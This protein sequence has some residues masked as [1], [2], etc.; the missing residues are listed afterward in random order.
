MTERM[1]DLGGYRLSVRTTGT[2][3]PAV[4][5]LASLGGGNDEWSAVA[6]LLSDTTHVVTYARA[7]IEDSNPLPADHAEQLRTAAWFATQLRTLLQ[8]LEIGPPYIFATGSIG[9]FIADRYAETWPEEVAG[10][11]LT[12]PTNPSPFRAAPWGERVLE[13]GD[14][15][16]RLR[17]SDLHAELKQPRNGHPVRAVVV[18]SAVGRWLRGRADEWAP[19]TL[20]EVDQRWQ[21][22][23]R[24]WVQRWSAQQVVADTAGHHVCREEPR[25]VATVVS[26]MVAAAREARDVHLD[27]GL[28]ATVGGALH[29]P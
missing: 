21:A 19:M 29:M 28:L 4:V 27:P 12:D 2:F 18:S 9:A 22:H 10:L 3:A 20:E 25:L 6:E 26:A 1:V 17:T 23:Q 7:G 24:E 14:G 11:V 16:A 5:C 13:D 8:R 15:G